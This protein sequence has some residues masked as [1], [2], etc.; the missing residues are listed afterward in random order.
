M[1]RY[2]YLTFVNLSYLIHQKSADRKI[3]CDCEQ[4]RAEIFCFFAEKAK[5][6]SIMLPKIEHSRGQQLVT[7]IAPRGTQPSSLSEPLHSSQSPLDPKLPL[8]LELQHAGQRHTVSLPT[9]SLDKTKKYFVTFTIN[10]SK[11]TVLT[12]LETPRQETQPS[13]T[14]VQS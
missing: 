3:K 6:K 14:A 8:T 13:A 4:L 1:A 12:P 2:Y 10:S 5:S 11:K 9:E 7:T